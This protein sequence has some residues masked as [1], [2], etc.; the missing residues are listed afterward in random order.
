MLLNIWFIY[1]VKF[2]IAF[3]VLCIYFDFRDCFS[4]VPASVLNISSVR[5]GRRATIRLFFICISLHND[6]GWQH[7]TTRFPSSS[8]TCLVPPELYMLLLH[9]RLVGMAQSIR[10][11]RSTS[12]QKCN[13]KR[14]DLYFVIHKY[15]YKYAYCAVVYNSMHVISF[16]NCRFVASHNFLIC[17]HFIHYV[18]LIINGTHIFLLSWDTLTMDH[19]FRVWYRA[20]NKL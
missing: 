8:R 1:S 5:Y 15:T 6:L 9:M 20:S 3:Y 14:W 10:Q 17:F 18:F 13:L 2:H 12:L 19:A 4:G 11:I 16:T 7:S